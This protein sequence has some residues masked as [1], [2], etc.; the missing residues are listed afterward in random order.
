[1]EIAE[2]FGRPPGTVRSQL[3]RGLA[4]LR[5]LL[6]RGREP[7]ALYRAS[8]LLAVGPGMLDE[9]LRANLLATVREEVVR[10]A[11]SH[12]AEA[13][14]AGGARALTAGVAVMALAGAAWLTRSD[15]ASPIFEVERA[16]AELEP[17]VVRTVQLEG[18]EASPGQRPP[19][20]RR[21][22]A[23]PQ[24]E[25]AEHTPR[26]RSRTRREEQ[27]TVRAEGT[28]PPRESIAFRV[29]PVVDTYLVP[30]LDELATVRISARR[31]RAELGD[32]HAS[33]V[34]WSRFDG[35][36][37]GSYASPSEVPSRIVVRIDHPG[38]L[39]AEAVVRARTFR[40]EGDAYVARPKVHLEPAEDWLEVYG[41]KDQDD[42]S[43]W[44]VAVDRRDDRVRVLD[45]QPLTVDPVRDMR[46]CRLRSRTAWGEHFIAV[47]PDDPAAHG[48]GVALAGKGPHEGIVAMFAVVPKPQ[49]VELE[50][51][52]PW[53]APMSGLGA[54]AV[55]RSDLLRYPP[56]GQRPVTLRGRVPCDATEEALG[57]ASRA[58]RQHDQELSSSAAARAMAEASTELGV[59][60]VTPTEALVF[61]PLVVEAKT[62]GAVLS[63]TGAHPSTHAFLLTA[64]EA[65]RLPGAP[66]ATAWGDVE[67]S[68]PLGSVGANSGRPVQLGLTDLGSWVHTSGPNDRYQPRVPVGGITVPLPR[69]AA[70]AQRGDVE[71]RV[72]SVGLS[73]PGTIVEDGHGAA[74]ALRALV[75]PRAIATVEVGLDGTD[76]KWTGAGIAGPGEARFVEL[77]R[78]VGAQPARGER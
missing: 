26:P 15:A 30:D 76:L 74:P 55:V 12:G 27:R 44:L 28:E 67:S 17:V 65:W 70:E 58:A 38:A 64:E 19:R 49:T 50:P 56:R 53:D 20:A 45:R 33:S 18:I 57:P 10:T 2:R 34:T 37:V 73:L 32:L 16:P 47:L 61:L 5:E 72:E 3:H 13:A 62:A 71:F 22:V 11:A 23:T 60:I 43:V 41:P 36:P 48:W 24:A 7:G 25:N 54:K 40:R 14:A 1:L 42:G 6:E 35:V 46:S 21:A 78:A 52:D 69:D 29:E 63:L 8:A 66:P 4:R 68:L 51:I 9:T 75:P 77:R 31:D 59:R 39:P